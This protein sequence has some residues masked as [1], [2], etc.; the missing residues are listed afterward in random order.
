MEINIYINDEMFSQNADV[1]KINANISN[2]ILITLYNLISPPPVTPNPQYE[3]KLN[4]FAAS[5]LET[6]NKSFIDISK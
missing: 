5:Y 2:I 4:T 1:N 6:A 3:K